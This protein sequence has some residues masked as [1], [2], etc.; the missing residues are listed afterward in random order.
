MTIYRVIDA[1]INRAR[2]GIR[3]I[4]DELRFIFEKKELS[5]RLRSLRHEIS[6]IPSL[7]NIS[8][9]KLL[10]S[11]Q[12]QK[13]VGKKRIESK[14]KN[15]QEIIASNFSRVEESIRVLEEYSKLINSKVTDKIKKIRFDLYVLQK[16]I[17]LSIYRKELTSKLGL[18]II[19]DEK[20]AG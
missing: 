11:R 5:E 8:S 1:N 12:S 17:Q 13:D 20:I 10:V 7:L 19:T 4:E 18:Y 14:R 6:R 16:E 3:V 9:I 15:L 2:E